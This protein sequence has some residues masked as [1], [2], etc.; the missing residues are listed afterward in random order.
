MSNGYKKTNVNF[1]EQGKTFVSNKI[2]KIAKV[3]T[4][5]ETKESFTG[6][7]G[8]NGPMDAKNRAEY[9]QTN[10]QVAAMTNNLAQY[11]TANTKLNK[12]TSDYLANKDN[13]NSNRNYNMFVSKY[14]NP[15][16]KN[17]SRCVP[18]ANLTNLPA[19]INFAAAYPALGNGE[20]N[21]KSFGEARKACNTWANDAGSGVFAVTKD[22]NTRVYDCHVGKN[23]QTTVPQYS[24]PTT[25]YAL[26]GAASATANKGGLF[27]NGL[28]GVY[29]KSSV[30]P[31]PKCAIASMPAPFN[32]TRF[33]NP[34]NNPWFKS[35]AWGYGFIPDA[36]AYWIWPDSNAPNVMGYSTSYLY[37]N[38]NNTT[39]ANLMANVYCVA[40]NYADLTLNGTPIFTYLWAAIP[41]KTVALQ[42]GSNIFEIRVG[43]AGGPG[44]VVFVV[45]ADKGDGSGMRTLFKSGDAGWGVAE[46]K[47]TSAQMIV[48][49]SSGPIANPTNINYF[50]GY[51]L[52]SP[53]LVP[54]KACDAMKGGDIY[55]PSIA[56][57]YGRN[58]SNRTQKS[59]MVRYIKIKNRPTQAPLGSYLQIAQLVVMGYNKNNQITN[60]ALKGQA[61]AS[62]VFAPAQNAIDGQQSA[63]PYPNIFHSMGVGPAE[64][65]QLDLGGS[66]AIT[67]II[68][69]NRGDC[70][71]SRADGMT[72]E[73][74]N[75]LPS[76]NGTPLRTLTLNSALK[77]EF[78]ITG[79]GT[80]TGAD[81]DCSIYGEDDVNLPKA[82]ITQLWNAAGCTTTGTDANYSVWTPQSK[83][84]LVAGFADAA[85]F[86]DGASR[87]LC[88]GPDKT[89]WPAMDPTKY[90]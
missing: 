50:S 36:T 65:W 51:D 35:S 69:Y 19:D 75:T 59:L 22:P 72:V 68:Y 42:P 90:K 7:L 27:A 45:Q 37:Y 47:C 11:T 34:T 55:R 30:K 16:I 26:T 39:D 87:T 41:M 4:S 80:G 21:F 25:A 89:K 53:S 70:C 58:C 18:A 46:A 23:N 32:Q 40:D 5:D 67:Q 74:W 62:S 20:S 49:N 77:Q 8:T 15:E 43:N 3:F 84:T 38:Y 83:K 31:T 9:T 57:T 33:D 48:S 71:Q 82:C 24:K 64:F 44:A 88:Y 76:P 1:F 29:T 28:I 85:T 73:L 81:A 2:N 86:P 54:Y 66:F 60:L 14:A 17:F 78:N 79:T 63:K 61:T 52:N 13:Y 56:A 10:S 6:I 12:K